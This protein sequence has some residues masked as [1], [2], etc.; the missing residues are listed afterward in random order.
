MSEYYT[1][2]VYCEPDASIPSYVGKGKDG[3]AFKHIKAQT[4]FGRHLRASAARGDFPLFVRVQQPS[5]R[6]ALN[7]E[8]R[9]IALHGR[10]DKGLGPL[11]NLT[12]G[13]EGSS[14]WTP[15]AETCRKISAANKGKSRPSTVGAANFNRGR[16]WWTNG[17][18]A[19]KAATCPGDGFVR[20]RKTS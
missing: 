12:D 18:V 19:L 2:T 15:S 16:L 13:G 8:V 20:G 9:L 3:R 5:E 1:Y 10:K 11:Y 6:A 7:E 4:Y 14:G 17:V